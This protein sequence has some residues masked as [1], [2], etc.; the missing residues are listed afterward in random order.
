MRFVYNI[1]ICRRRLAEM[2]WEQKNLAEPGLSESVISKFFRGEIVRN[3]TAAQIVYNLGLRMKD[4][5]M[6]EDELEDAGP[7]RRR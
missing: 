5:L 1:D 3:S 7:G 6:D 4:V 2:G